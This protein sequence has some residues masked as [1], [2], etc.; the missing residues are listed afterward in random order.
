MVK[1]CGHA[2]GAPIPAHA[3][4]NSGSPRWGGELSSPS[5]LVTRSQIVN[6]GIDLLADRAIRLSEVV[7]LAQK[8]GWEYL[9][10]DGVNVQ[11]VCAP[12]GRL[13]WASAAL[14]GRINDITAARRH[15]LPKKIGNLLG[16]L[17]DVPLLRRVSAGPDLEAGHR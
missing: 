16:I 13:L 7:R 4:P 3:P 8:A 2:C 17:A 11:T 9:L 15:R 5:R 14:P 12:D 1:S 6:E 10:I